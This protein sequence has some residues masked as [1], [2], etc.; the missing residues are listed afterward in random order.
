[1]VI[2]IIYTRE[3]RDETQS[4][5]KSREYINLIIEVVPVFLDEFISSSETSK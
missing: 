1:M 3:Q 5:I 4:N 2:M